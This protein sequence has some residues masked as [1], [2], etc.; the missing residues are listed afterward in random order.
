MNKMF[1][2]FGVS[3]HNK[4]MLW[5]IECI[6]PRFCIPICTAA[7]LYSKYIKI[8][9]PSDWLIKKLGVYPQELWT[10]TGQQCHSFLASFWPNFWPINSSAS[11]GSG[12][13]ESRDWYWQHWTYGIHSHYIWALWLLNYFRLGSWSIVFCWNLISIH[14]ILQHLCS[15][16]TVNDSDL[17]S[18]IWIHT[19]DLYLL[20]CIAHLNLMSCS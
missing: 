10:N 11:K 7:F 18:F 16:A 20:G 14:A 17:L 4:T 8:V 6:H 13:S 9:N 15:H 3:N 5:H 1:L 19:W 2:L 12:H